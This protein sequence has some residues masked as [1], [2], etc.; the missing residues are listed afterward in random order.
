MTKFYAFPKSEKLTSRNR[1]F[2]I[3]K[4]GK[5][6]NVYPLHIK[7]AILDCLPNSYIQVAFSVS[8]K[9]FKRAVERNLIKRRMREA[10][11]LNKTFLVEF[12]KANHLCIGIIFSFVDNEVRDYKE[13]EFSIIS[14]LNNIFSVLQ[15]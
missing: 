13:I 9:K 10:Y 6:F 5:K 15:K 8:K 11:R 3:V 7:W 12:L 4:K 2:Y 14:A 1:L